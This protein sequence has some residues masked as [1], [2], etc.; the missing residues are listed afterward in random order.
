MKPGLGLC[1]NEN[2]FKKGQRNLYIDGF[3]TMKVKT[4][5]IQQGETTVANASPTVP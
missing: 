3:L 5:P 2:P 1:G 4:L